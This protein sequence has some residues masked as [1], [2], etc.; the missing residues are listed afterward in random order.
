MNPPCHRQGIGKTNN[1]KPFPYQ[2][3]LKVYGCYYEYQF[4]AADIHPDNVYANAVPWINIKGYWLRQAGFDINMP[5]MVE[6]S[7][8]KIVLTT[9][10]A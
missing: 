6:V 7:K 9:S 10:I 1:T 8:G 2:R 3:T 5:L 4:K